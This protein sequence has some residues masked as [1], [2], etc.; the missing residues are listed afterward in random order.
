MA[1]GRGRYELR[2]LTRCISELLVLVSNIFPV[3]TQISVFPFLFLVYRMPVL[4]RLR[5]R[6]ELPCM[7]SILILCL[8]Y[9][10]RRCALFLS[11]IV[12]WRW[13]GHGSTRRGRWEVPTG[14]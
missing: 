10:R 9:F 6:V 2:G 11:I 3:A 4:F 14:R 12:Y 5:L 7:S 8:V 13:R 1:W